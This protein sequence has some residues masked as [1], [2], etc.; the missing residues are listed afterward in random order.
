MR[1]YTHLAQHQRCQIHALL[2][3]KTSQTRIG[4]I[5]GVHKSTISREVRRNRGK[6]EYFPALA[7]RLAL[8]RR[9]DK[10]LRRI[11][12]E[13]WSLVEH[14]LRREQW[15]PEQISGWLART[16]RPRVS[17]ERIY[18]YVLDDKGRGGDLHEHLRCRKKRRKR[19]GA[20]H[21][22]GSIP[23]RTSIDERPAAAERRERLGDWEADTMIGKG[24]RQVLVSVVDRRSRL[25]RL[26]KA[27][28][29][30]AK[31]VESAM[32]SLLGPLADRV[33]TI[34][35][36]NG[37]EFARH[38]SLST[39]LKALF[40]F[41]HPYAAWQRGLNE[42]TNGLIR[43]YFPKS[44]DFLT[45]TDDEIQSVMDRLNNRPRKS[46]G[47]KTPNEVFFGPHHLLHLGVEFSHD[48]AP[49]RRSRRKIG[50]Q[51]PRN[52]P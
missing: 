12:P 11:P 21:R 36:D 16:G 41:A 40:F 30:G 50:F 38:A 49:Q 4:Q 33:H 51:S 39:S 3:E 7:H 18:Q 27:P 52:L 44:R 31:E 29:R 20:H 45:I 2:R 28:R 48:L 42:N 19:Y 34:T 46:L 5:L 17:H 37:S 32:L 35:S 24:S 1:P 47:F 43:Q 14:L 10:S 9:R 26:A 13:T 8:D 25:T 15:S 22:R 23:N 6:Y